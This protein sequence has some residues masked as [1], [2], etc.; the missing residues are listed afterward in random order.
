[1]AS[2]SKGSPKKPKG[3]LILIIGGGPLPKA[4]KGAK[5][6]KAPKKGR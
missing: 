3:G 2:S 6:P 4:P 5:P 1:M